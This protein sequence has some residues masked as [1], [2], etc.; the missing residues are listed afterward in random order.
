MGSWKTPGYSC[1]YQAPVNINDGTSARACA[2]RPGPVQQADGWWVREYGR[3]VGYLQEAL[4]RA[5]IGYTG[6]A[7]TREV[8]EDG[9]AV[10]QGILWDLVEATG[11]VLSSGVGA[12]VG[13]AA[14]FLA[15]G[16]GPAPG[17]AAALVG[18]MT[19]GEGLLAWLGLG[20]LVAPLRAHFEE[21]G[22]QFGR[23]IL[24]GWQSQGDSAALEAAAREFGATIGFFVRLVLQGLVGF[25]DGSTGKG[26]P[27]ADRALGAGA[28]R[29]VPNQPA[30]K[31]S[32]GAD[33]AFGPL[34]GSRL[35]QICRG[36]GPWLV[37]NLPKLRARFGKR[38]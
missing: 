19:I 3:R 33:R 15:G 18:G 27:G 5:Q 16:P 8:G 26:S 13:G 6:M 31:P 12:T 9:Y 11:A 17:A 25:L 22:A 37:A 14:G 24:R 29:V 32:P 35:F 21:L 34:R 2:P 7:V 28:V 10:V 30:G 1:V 36:L 20:A 4:T 23:A 38:P